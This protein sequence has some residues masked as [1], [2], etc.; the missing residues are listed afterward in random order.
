MELNA[1]Q[2]KKDMEHCINDDCDKC[3]VPFGNCQANLIESA[4]SLIT[5]QEQE[6]E[7][8]AFLISE[9]EKEKREL[10]EERNRIYNDLQ[11]WKAIAE[12]YRKQFEEAK[13]D[14]VRE[15][16]LKVEELT[17]EVV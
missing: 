13:P 2:I 10:W 9:L 3:S 12:Q 7:K 5:S 11:D 14:T 17:E 16:R 8:L 4:L 1:E 6:K 15:I